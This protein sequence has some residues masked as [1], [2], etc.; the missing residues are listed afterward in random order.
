MVEQNWPFEGFQHLDRCV[1]L[2]KPL[3]LTN[4]ANL[5]HQHMA[6]IFLINLACQKI[7]F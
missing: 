1:I 7:L 5:G 4:F 6:P 2:M 3:W